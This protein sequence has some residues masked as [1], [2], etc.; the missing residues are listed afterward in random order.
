MNIETRKQMCII[1][2]VLMFIALFIS[3]V[4]ILSVNA[5]QV[6]MIAAQ[7][8]STVVA[9]DIGGHWAEKQIKDWNEKGFIKGY[10]DNTFKPNNTITRAEFITLVNNVFGYKEKAELSF[11]DIKSS[12]WYFSEI[13]KAIEA[14]YVKGYA[15]GTIKPNNEI[16]RQ[17]VAMVISN[18]MRLEMDE[19]SAEI[20]KLKDNKAIQVWSKGA[21]GAVLEKG[22]M[23]GYT[24]QTF[25]TGNPITR[26]EATVALN[27]VAGS[28]YNKA[29]TYGDTTIAGNVSVSTDGVSLKNLNIKGDLYLTEGIGEGTVILDNVTV[30]GKTLVCGGGMESIIIKNSTLGSTVVQKK[31]GK[32]RLE[33]SGKTK[34]GKMQLRSGGK[35]EEKE[36]S[37]V[38]FEDVE[39]KKDKSDSIVQFDGDF[40]NVDILSESK[41]EVTKGN[42][43]KLQ[44]NEGAKDAEIKVLAGK[45]E[46]I[47]IKVKVKVEVSGGTIA[48]VL[49]D[50]ASTGSTVDVKEGA[51]ITSLIAEAIIEVLGKGIVEVAE[52]KISGVKFEVEPVKVVAENNVEVQIGPDPTPVPTTV[53][54]VTPTPTKTTSSGSSSGGSSS[55]G[56]TTTPRINTSLDVISAFEDAVYATVYNED[57]GEF[58]TDLAVDNF[59]LTIDSDEVGLEEVNVYYNE[60]EIIPE[61]N[62]LSGL[63]TLTFS[64]SG[65]RSA[66]AEFEIVESATPT[67]TVTPTPTPTVSSTPV[68][69]ATVS[70]TPTPALDFVPGEGGE[71]TFTPFTAEENKIGGLYI[72]K[73]HDYYSIIFG[74]SPLYHH[75]VE[76]KFIP[77]QEYGATGYTLQYSED[78]GSTWTDFETTITA[79]QDNIIATDPSQTTMYR[80]VVI[81]GDKDKYTSNEVTADIPTIKTEFTG[82]FLDESMSISGVMAPWVGRGLE[83]S[84]TAEKQN[85]PEPNTVATDVYMTYQWYRVNPVSYEM[86]AVEGATDLTYNTTGDDVGYNLLVRAT[87]DNENISGFIQ[88][89][90]SWGVLEQNNACISN[91]TS[92]GFTLNLYKTVP[93]L[94]ASE[95]SLIDYNG[96]S[97]TINSV[98]QGANAAIYNI[99][100]NLDPVK[101][102]FYLSN[103]SDFWRI[104]FEQEEGHM[105]SESIQIPY[106][107]ERY[108]I[109]VADVVGGAASVGTTP[110]F[111]AAEGELITVYISNIE[112]GKKFKSIVVTDTESGLV[113]TTVVTAGEE[114]TFTMPAKEVTVTVEMEEDVIAV[115]TN[116]FVEGGT[117]NNSYDITAS[118]TFGSDTTPSSIDGNVTISIGGV[119]LTNMTISGDLLIAEGV[120]EGDVNLTNVAVLG[121]TIVNGG[122]QNSIH[123]SS[124]TTLNTIEV[125]D[126]TA[127]QNVR[128]VADD[129]AVV[130][131]VVMK[132]GCTIEANTSVFEALYFVDNSS[133]GFVG[134]IN[135]NAPVTS[136][137]VGT[138]VGNININKEGNIAVAGNGNVGMID[139]SISSMGSTSSLTVSMDGYSSIGGI[140]LN[141]LSE[142]DISIDINVLSDVVNYVKSNDGCSVEVLG[143]YSNTLLDK[144]YDKALSVIQQGQ[145]DIVNMPETYGNKSG[146]QLLGELKYYYY[147]LAAQRQ[148]NYD[149]LSN[150]FSTLYE[151]WVQTYPFVSCGINLDRIPRYQGDRLS[152][153]DSVYGLYETIPVDFTYTNGDLYYGEVGH[154]VYLTTKQD[155]LNGIVDIQ[156]DIV[157]PR[158]SV[159]EA[160]YESV[161][162]VSIVDLSFTLE[163]SEASKLAIQQI[164]TGNTEK[165]GLNPNFTWSQET[166]TEPYGSS[167][168]YKLR[169][170]FSEGATLTTGDIITIPKASVIPLNTYQ[171]G[172]CTDLVFD[173]NN[174]MRP[175][176]P[177]M[178]GTGGNY[179]IMGEVRDVTD[180]VNP[181]GASSIVVELYYNESGDGLTWVKVG[182][183]ITD[184]AGSFNFASLVNGDYKVKVVNDLGTVQGNGKSF[185]ISNDPSNLVDAN[186]DS[187]TIIILNGNQ[188]ITGTPVLLIQIM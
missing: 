143:D 31:N 43:A 169:I 175:I 57:D 76:L 35:L 186:G 126:K 5:Q 32:V 137:D 104:T 37:G 4:L 162:Y 133:G 34:V 85:Y 23:K 108:A 88:V 102:P 110:N 49:M 27:N 120:G 117:F 124:G 140:E 113:G 90:S 60:W 96:D 84:F 152:V 19:N 144:I 100:A 115:G 107:V 145:T 91:A 87:G 121:N 105:I 112:E 51:T 111:E 63:Y 127:D 25:K 64:K 129:S 184:S 11:T 82:Y 171:T 74:G 44:A 95:L 118:G 65:Y 139:M 61:E 174:R 10:S 8:I 136:L 68:P 83:A 38:G 114:Y 73:N 75:Y 132:S 163:L 12:D 52:V 188:Y 89:M 81:G 159:Q 180:P 26:A 28:I 160:V 58:I 161:N 78:S 21:I 170:E 182:T 134:D 165:Y 116:V 183:L 13:A 79:T 131:D 185:S 123:L 22:Y 167:I 103:D 29:G 70:V 72:E 153:L 36:L 30:G 2:S 109:T 42:I 179:S 14:G 3:D 47:E 176:P 6:N 173:V 130:G 41:I 33:A 77:A 164:F 53:A 147:P 92:T 24:D 142:G 55:G 99:S 135:I 93:G 166:V 20:S 39:V 181:V 106:S 66:S 156:S 172:V 50:K 54:V 146:E 98:T 151:L 168:L 154:E 128:I 149:T 16:S 187:S 178:G 101:G 71:I 158:I 18:I 80:L 46:S 148:A 125:E 94:T 97:V 141:N 155:L 9:K 56:S 138:D 48:N 1:L 69:T 177:S 17:E 86:T 45:I 59:T 40:N 7:S 150:E 15:D 157:L 122:G 62:L 119:T 67:A